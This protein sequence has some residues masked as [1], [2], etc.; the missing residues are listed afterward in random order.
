MTGSAP[1]EWKTAKEAADYLGVSYQT[2]RNKIRHVIAS[3]RIGDSTKYRP[4]DLDAYAESQRV[5]P[6]ETS[7]A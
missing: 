3:H 6:T 1:R 5:E 7:A 4:E 2:F